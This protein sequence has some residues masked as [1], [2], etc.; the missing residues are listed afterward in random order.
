MPGHFNHDIISA[1][2]NS[3]VKLFWEKKDLRRMLNIAG[4]DAALIAAQDW[5]A[6]KYHIV[7]PI[8]DHL[9]LTPEGIGPLRRILHETL[10]YKDAKHLLRY[11]DGKDRRRDAEE[12]LATLRALVEAHNEA[13]VT[14]EDEAESRRLRA[15]ESRKQARFNERLE[16]LKADYT[17][18]VSSSDEHARGI[19]LEAL[20]DE[21]FLL[22]E[23][24]P[25]SSFRRKGEQI[26]GSFRMDGEH[27]LIEAKW[28]AHASNLGDLRDL[29]GAVG[30]SL[31]NTL[32]LFISIN[33]FT[34]EALEG[35]VQGNR[36]R[37]FCMDG[38]DLY[39]V[40]D[41]RIDLAELLGR[42][43]DSAAQR[44]KIFVPASD[45]IAGKI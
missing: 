30:S 2:N 11:T 42:K 20:L 8:I 21:L 38:G 41:Q 28:T 44:R 39:L 17:R 15:E 36:P 43:K 19:A 23:L 10:L 3:A 4:V 6:Y 9:N 26:D 7:G 25:H 27:Y 13:R 22:F 16:H 14:A 40:L 29:D 12:A 5:T 33:G 1:L 37:L 18:L 45:I 35:Y 24:A 31:D 34:P 32:G